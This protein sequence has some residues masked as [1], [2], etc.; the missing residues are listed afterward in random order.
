M[1]GRQSPQRELYRPD[2]LYMDFVGEDSFYGTLAG[3]RNGLFCDEDFAD[4][5]RV[6]NGRPS[7]PPSQ[8]CIALLLQAHAAV[9]DQEAIARTAYDLRWKVALGLHIEEK[10]CAKSTL[11]EFRAKLIL[12]ERYQEIF[13]ASVAACRM[14]GLLNSKRKGSI[15]L[16]TTPIFGRGAVRDTFNLVSD[17]IRRIVGEYV[18][19]KGLNTEEVIADQGLERHFGKSFK[20]EADINWQDGNEKRTLLGELVEDAQTAL[21]LVADGL[22]GYKR[23]SDKTQK[24]RESGGL[25][26]ELLLQEIDEEPDDDGPPKVRRDKTTDR[27]LSTT[28][29]EMRRGYKSRTQHFDGYKAA[30][31]V[32][33]DSGV[34]LAT[35]AQPGN[36]HDSAEAAKLVEEAQRQ[37][38]DKVEEVLGDA[39]YGSQKTRAELKALG[40]EVIAKVPGGSRTLFRLDDFKIDAGHGV[41]TCPAGKKSTRQ[42][43][44]HGE[45]GGVRYVFGREDC[46]NCPLRSKCTR[47]RAGPRTVTVGIRTRELEKLRRHQ[48]TK[49]FRKRY[50]RRVAVEHAIARLTRL[51]VRQARYFGRDKVAFQ[52]TLAATVVNLSLAAGA[53]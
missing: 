24:L 38:H 36:V 51:G 9:S 14:S 42:D 43:K 39:A 22:R 50:R 18:S 34:I 5:Y 29:P 27:I 46:A 4:L 8:L 7:V 44:V 32:E 48:E 16:D 53:A 45:L 23:G 19:L 12:N 20:G 49:T 15:A 26:R 30:V 21:N 6:D 40:V 17:Q 1:L 33:T 35:D 25:L 11:Q 37:S 13:K 3:L 31:A 41:A 28:D 47:S 52:V 2:N 10:L